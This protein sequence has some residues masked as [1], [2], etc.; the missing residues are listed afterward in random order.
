MPNTTPLS[1]V[2]LTEALRFS[3][4]AVLV[5]DE[6]LNVIHANPAAEALFESPVGR[7]LTRWL[8]GDRLAREWETFLSTGGSSIIGAGPQQEPGYSVSYAAAMNGEAWGLIAV[9][10]PGNRQAMIESLLES[11]RRESRLRSVG[12]MTAGVAHNLNNHLGAL[13]GYIQLMRA[14]ADPPYAAELERAAHDAAQIVSRLQEFTVGAPK[15]LASV[16]CDLNETLTSILRLLRPR[17]LDEA[18]LRDI[19]YEFSLEFGD[20]PRVW[21]YGAAIAEVAQNLILNAL[22]AMPRGGAITVRTWMPREAVAAFSIR[23]SGPGIGAALLPR[24]F[25][26]FERGD[27]SGHGLGLYTCQFLVDRLGGTIRARNHPDG[28]AEFVVELRVA[29]ASKT[30]A[31]PP[32]P[33][34][35]SLQ[36]AAVLVV[37][38]QPDLVEIAAAV[39][40]AAGARIETAPDGES[41]MERFAGGTFDV[42]LSDMGLPDMSGLKLLAFVLARDPGCG[43]ALMTGFRIDDPEIVGAD[44][45]P[46]ATIGKPF[47]IGALRACVERAR[48][49]GRR[50]RAGS[51]R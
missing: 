38:D 23:D 15:D 7:P 37:D 3:P 11:A 41:A 43:V 2:L 35:E 34:G 10:E 27:A 20:V 32:E 18:R 16:A 21:G 39:L 8:G 12:E 45:S 31:P 42:V 46:D 28:G 50:R 6:D 48:A 19:P 30:L 36:G 25:Q 51:S 44:V 33:R 1:S 24:L 14:A 4:T 47:D 49:A 17:W 13:L 22:R 5:A 29:A 40:S 26:P 9:V